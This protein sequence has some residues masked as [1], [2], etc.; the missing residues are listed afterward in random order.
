MDVQCFS[1][2][3]RIDMFVVVV[4]VVVV[5]VIVRISLQSA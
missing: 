4:V 3:E 5:V 2:S 1:R